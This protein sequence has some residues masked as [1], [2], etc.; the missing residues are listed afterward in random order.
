MTEKDEEKTYRA[1]DIETFV[2]D[3]AKWT[4]VSPPALTTGAKGAYYGTTTITV[5]HTSGTYTY[6]GT[7]STPPMP[8]LY[9]PK[10]HEED[11]TIVIDGELPSREQFVTNA[12][13]RHRYAAPWSCM[14]ELTFPHDA[15][16][17][18]QE[19]FAHLAQVS[20][21]AADEWDELINSGTDDEDD[22]E[23]M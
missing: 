16:R 10:L 18:A 2:Y 5:P 13:M 15:E 9:F 23:S 20:L 4:S 17:A 7:T 1:G 22:D 6:P 11:E 3:G 19:Y 12:L 14:C 8:P 21:E